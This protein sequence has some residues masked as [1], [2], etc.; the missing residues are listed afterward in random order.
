MPPFD[1][2]MKAGVLPK[3]Q[4][5]TYLSS[6][7]GDH[8]SV[9]IFGGY[10]AKYVQGDF[11]QVKFDA[12]QP[13]LG[14][15]AVTLQSVSKDGK[16]VAG[17]ANCIGV[18]D[19]GTSVIAGPPKDFQPIIDS[20]NITADCSNIHT[21]PPISF[22][23]ADKEFELTAEDYVVHLPNGSGGE[24][25]VLAMEAF[26]AGEGLFDIW[27]LGAS[28]AAA[29][30]CTKL[31]CRLPTHHAV[32]SQV[33]P[34]SASM[35]QSSTV[36]ATRCPLPWLRSFELTAGTCGTANKRSLNAFLYAV[37]CLTQAYLLSSTSC[38]LQSS[39]SSHIR[40]AAGAHP[41]ARQ[42]A[43]HPRRALL[44][45]TLLLKQGLQ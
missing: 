8:E 28:P 45:Q 23:M 37:C 19:T 12:L 9:L 15:W 11:T 40:P 36:T 35:A 34:S 1:N 41:S 7:P 39:P 30:A 10:D 4:F 3:N 31:A 22:K 25:C 16:V 17:C 32:F 24:E 43:R 5:F 44:P 13:I 21:L 29:P 14:Y 38:R 2:L 27:I 18:V 42:Q 26:D 20:L 33:T 6:A